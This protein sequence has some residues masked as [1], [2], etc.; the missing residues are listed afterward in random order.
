MTG[1]K[2]LSTA[3]PSC[4]RDASDAVRHLAPI[5]PNRL[6]QTIVCCFP[7]VSRERRK[8]VG[9]HSLWPTHDTPQWPPC[10]TCARPAKRGIRSTMVALFK[11]G[12]N[13]EIAQREHLYCQTAAQ[14]DNG[15][16]SC[17]I[18]MWF[19]VTLSMSTCLSVYLSER[20]RAV[21]ESSQE[22]FSF[23]FFATL[24]KKHFKIMTRSG[25][26]NQV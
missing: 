14:G 2:W 25:S 5:Q 16:A 1:R 19:F 11:V 23:F 18:T 3:G 9:F 17:G 6:N 24:E 7:A 21:I 12:M 15:V 26:Y 20:G 22:Y 10:C 4:H 13:K 8:V